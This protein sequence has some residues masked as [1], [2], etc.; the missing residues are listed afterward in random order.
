MVPVNYGEGKQNRA[1]M[2]LGEVQHLL[3]GRVRRKSPVHSLN[4]PD[5]PRPEMPAFRR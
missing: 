1:N 3:A 2:N 4:K 5:D